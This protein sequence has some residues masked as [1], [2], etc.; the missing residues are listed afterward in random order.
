MLI[1]QSGMRTERLERN[2]RG[3]LQMFPKR[4]GRGRKKERSC[5]KQAGWKSMDR[6]GN[7]QIPAS[8]PVRKVVTTMIAKIPVGMSDA[9]G[10]RD[11]S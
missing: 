9:R 3:S 1:H 2:K 7:L 8:A 11:V 5:Q 6:K 10:R 4:S